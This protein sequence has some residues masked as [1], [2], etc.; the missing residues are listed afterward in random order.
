MGSLN[1]VWWVTGGKCRLWPLTTL[2]LAGLRFPCCQCS[3]ENSLHPPDWIRVPYCNRRCGVPNLRHCVSRS[4]NVGG[5]NFPIGSNFPNKYQA[6]PTRNS[7]PPKIRNSLRSLLHQV[8]SMSESITVQPAADLPLEERRELAIQFLREN[9]SATIAT[10]C[11]DYNLDYKAIRYYMKR[12]AQIKSRGGHNAILSASQM[13]I[14]LAWNTV[15]K[16][17]AMMLK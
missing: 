5:S 10:V 13:M 8:N 9:S 3:V 16:K 7:I 14:L 1:A 12:P 2:M 6:P 11:R 4:L 17:T 15:R